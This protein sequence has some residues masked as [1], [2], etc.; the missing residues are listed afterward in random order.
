MAI[1]DYLKQVEIPITTPTSVAAV[2]LKTRKVNP[3]VIHA[4]G[5][6]AQPTHA[7]G[8]PLYSRDFP[9]ARRR[10]TWNR[11]SAARTGETS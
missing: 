8:D 6:A 11:E 9:P 5:T 10:E 3:Y 1:E 4:V 2:D 7:L